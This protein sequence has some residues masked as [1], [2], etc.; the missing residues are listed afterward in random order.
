MDRGLLRTYPDLP[1][2]EFREADGRLTPGGTTG[3]A[4]VSPN[5]E[6]LAAAANGRCPALIRM[7][8]GKYITGL[9][10][11]QSTYAWS[12]EGT[13]LAYTRSPGA[14]RSALQESQLFIYDVQSG[15]DMQVTHFPPKDYRAWWNPFGR[16]SVHYPLVSG[17]SW[18][19]RANLIL[20]YV[21]PDRG[22]FLW[23]AEG[24]E[25]N[26][27]DDLHGECWRMTQLSADGRR[28]LYL[29]ST[30]LLPTQR[31]GPSSS[32]RRGRLSRSGCPDNTVANRC[33]RRR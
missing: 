2:A 21:A 14:T 22:V 1:V 18:A 29:S 30:R 15:E 33:H 4:R 9:S 12:P 8:D 26:R 7:S 24:R 23:S 16:P 11:G 3:P 10:E 27:I 31:G 32:R 28:V 6:L 17:V 5:G 13:R 20:F 25:V 19:R